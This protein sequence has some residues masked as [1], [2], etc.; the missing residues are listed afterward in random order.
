MRYREME[1]TLPRDILRG[2][3]GR[4]IVFEKNICSK[5]GGEGKKKEDKVRN[6]Q[7][8][9]DN[10]TGTDGDIQRLTERDTQRHG[11]GVGGGGGK[12]RQ[13]YRTRQTQKQR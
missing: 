8:D 6:S 7:R 2:S 11:Q 13:T 4:N 3:T 10:D 9:T 1:N 12:E 5:K